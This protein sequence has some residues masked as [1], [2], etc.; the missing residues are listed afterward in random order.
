MLR[1]RKVGL[2]ASN[3]V[4]DGD[5]AP[6]PQKGSRAP[7]FRP[8]SIAKRSPISATAEYLFKLKYCKTQILATHVQLVT[9]LG[10]AQTKTGLMTVN[11]TRCVV[12]RYVTSPTRDAALLQV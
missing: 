2:D 10:I 9:R 8:M 1:G 12:Q 5:P 6:P 3:I 11:A 4:L 7:N